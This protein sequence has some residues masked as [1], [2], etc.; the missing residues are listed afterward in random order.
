MGGETAFQGAQ[1]SKGSK[2][3]CWRE[4]QGDRVNVRGEGNQ[5]AR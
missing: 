4:E 1:R 2:Y 3:G 5:T